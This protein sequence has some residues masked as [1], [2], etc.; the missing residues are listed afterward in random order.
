[1]GNK[2]ALKSDGEEER[3]EENLRGNRKKGGSEKNLLNSAFLISSDP[4][5]D[6]ACFG[7]AAVNGVGTEKSGEALTFQLSPRSAELALV[8]A[9][10]N[11]QP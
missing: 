3:S 8:T 4:K 11:Y 10:V 2:L 6:P 7:N 5:S 1:M 9:E